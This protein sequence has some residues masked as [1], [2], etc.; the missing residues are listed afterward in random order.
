MPQTIRHQDSSGQS[1]AL[2][3]EQAFELARNSLQQ[4]DQ[5]QCLLQQV[6]EVDPRHADALNL[7]GMLHLQ[8]RQP[9]P[10][11]SCFEKAIALGEV[12]PNVAALLG[13]HLAGKGKRE[14]ALACF[15]HALKFPQP[16]ETAAGL[17]AFIAHTLND[18]ASNDRACFEAA[19][20][21]FRQALTFALEPKVRA[22]ALNGLGHALAQTGRF[23]DA[24][25]CFVEA[26]SVPDDPAP[27][28]ERHCNLGAALGQLGRLEEEVKCY[29][30]AIALAPA[31]LTR[32]N[33]SLAALRLGDFALGWREYEQRWGTGAPQGG[34]GRSFAEPLWAGGDIS[35]RRI[36]LHAEQGLG[37]TI[38]FVRYVPLV[39]ARGATVSLEVQPVLKRLLS[40]LPGP[41]AVIARGEPLP[42]FDVQC[43]LLSLP[44]AF[45]TVL[46]TIPGRIPY[47]KAGEEAR[48]AWA[49]RIGPETRLRVGLVW[50]GSPGHKKDRIRSVPVTSLAPLL[51]IPDVCFY[52]FQVGPRSADCGC[53]APYGPLSDL[54]PFLT[55]FHET[56]AA[57]APMD[58]LIS[59]DTS[60]AHLGGALGVETWV[61]L[62]AVAD[63]RWMTGRADS[64]W[65]PG[66][67]LFRQTAR[68]DWP[69]VLE[70]VREQLRDRAAR[71]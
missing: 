54:S 68:G 39:A 52:S 49:E 29:D 36:L 14:R 34:S 46:E 28:A 50:A 62:P 59:V 30:R 2:T 16:A 9:L 1:Q 41:A 7:L 43:P 10:A 27:T 12:S 48:Q 65:Y 21:H 64:P 67:R 57:L 60:V 37:D 40:G 61:L 55:D 35:G 32:F 19:I 8:A 69:P 58:L 44:L 70:Q 63:W 24:A 56:A 22:K 51:E 15:L 20:E 17:H 31:P 4:R 33:L 3:V 25:D 5:A 11:I 66:M 42:E 26:L 6:I 13:G 18:L 38:Q 47:L 23:E 45:G 53:L 71:H